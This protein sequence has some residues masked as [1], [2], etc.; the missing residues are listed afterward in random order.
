M[1]PPDNVTICVSKKK[2][3]K[4]EL[5]SSSLPKWRISQD[6]VLSKKGKDTEPCMRI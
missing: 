2:K 5:G 1:V 3:K 6:T 4:K